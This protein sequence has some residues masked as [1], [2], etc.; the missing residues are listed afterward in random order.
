[1]V[2]EEMTEQ[3]CRAI[4]AGT[5][6]VRLACARNNQPCI[7]PIHLDLDG[8]F[9][10]G[11]ATLGQTIEWIRQNPLVYLE[12]DELISPVQWASVVV[13]GHYE[14]LPQIPEYEVVALGPVTVIEVSKLVRRWNAR[15][16]SL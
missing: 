12:A 2:I 7:V 6:V 16:T 13:F 3:E 9:L 4:F 10:C 8:K 15:E 14:E 5:N 11:Y 1:M